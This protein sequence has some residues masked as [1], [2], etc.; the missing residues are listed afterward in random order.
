MLKIGIFGHTV[1]K[2]IELFFTPKDLLIYNKCYQ[3]LLSIIL[4]LSLFFLFL[5]F[6]L[7]AESIYNC[8]IIYYEKCTWRTF[9]LLKFDAC[10]QLRQCINGK[11][12]TFYNEC[13]GN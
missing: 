3:C 2:K 13:W 6:L 5:E 11:C 10:L 9:S 8:N 4:L 1:N 7:S 12:Q